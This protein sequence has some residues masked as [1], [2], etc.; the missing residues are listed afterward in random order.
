MKK[1][2][3]VIT[4]LAHK[5]AFESFVERSDAIQMI[6]GPHP[7]ITGK[8]MVPEDYSDFKIKNIKYFNNNAE[9]QRIVDKFKPNIFAPAYTSG[10]L[11]DL[12]PVSSQSAGVKKL[13]SK[14]MY[15]G[16]D[17]CQRI[18]KTIKESV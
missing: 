14:Y 9:L 10:E 1:I 15:T 11:Q 18:C 16:T 17:V 5:R 2:L 7:V 13:V 12:L 6:A 8:G 4:S 3:Y